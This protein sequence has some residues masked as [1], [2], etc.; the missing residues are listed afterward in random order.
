MDWTTAWQL[1]SE[2]C[3]LLAEDD[4]DTTARQHERIANKL[5]SRAGYRF[6]SHTQTWIDE[7][8][9]RP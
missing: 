3:D 6:S 1:A 5:Q 8:V 9:P 2:V 7:R 4:I